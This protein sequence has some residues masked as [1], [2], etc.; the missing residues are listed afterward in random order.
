M[1]PTKK[2]WFVGRVHPKNLIFS[3]TEHYLKCKN[4][5]DNAENRTYRKSLMDFPLPR[6]IS[7][8]EPNGN[9]K[10]IDGYHRLVGTPK[11]E[12]PLIIYCPRD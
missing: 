3:N 9:H 4:D 10:V 8:L 5:L 11:G 2:Q 6:G 7:V 12:H 1:Y